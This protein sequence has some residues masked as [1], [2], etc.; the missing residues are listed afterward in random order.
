[1]CFFNVFVLSN[2][3]TIRVSCC[4]V[5]YDFIIKTMLGSSLPPVVCSTAQFLLLYLYSFAYSGDKH[6]LHCVFV[7]CLHLVSC[8]PNVA[9]FSRLSIRFSLTFIFCTEALYNKIKLYGH[10]PFTGRFSYSY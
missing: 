10:K 9:S 8:T 4:D 3:F 5:R 7:V 2:V 6:I 1:M